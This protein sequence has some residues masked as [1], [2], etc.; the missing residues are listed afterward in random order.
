[1]I[2]IRKYSWALFL[3]LPF[4]GNGQCIYNGFDDAACNQVITSTDLCNTWD[5]NCGAGWQ[6]SSGTPSMVPYTTPKGLTKYYIFMWAQILSNQTY[7]ESM[8]YTLTAGNTFL[9]NHTYNITFDVVG[10]G[11]GAVNF[12]AANTLQQSALTTCGNNL[13]QLNANQRQLIGTVAAVNGVWV[14]SVTL[15]FVANANYNQIWIYPTSVD[16]NQ[17]SMG[18]EYLT[19]CEDPCPATLIYNTGVVPEGTS[20]AGNIIA[21]TGVPGTATVSIQPTQTTL[22]TADEVDLI[23]NFDATV[24]TGSFTATTGGC[25]G[26]RPMKNPNRED[27]DP[28]FQSGQDFMVMKTNS[29]PITQKKVTPGENL[30][31][32]VY[33]TIGTGIVNITGITGSSS[34]VSVFDQ[35]GKRVLVN[36]NTSKNDVNRLDLSNLS[37]GIYYI[38]IKNS[39][40]TINKKVIIYK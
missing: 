38:Q 14:N 12:Y 32:R 16:A 30:G 17:Y 9:A 4:Y 39:F 26:F 15:T 36:R 13:P 5:A 18:I 10:T 29:S 27:Y 28:P 33:P 6:R 19:A 8:F 1:M 3:F 40:G 31:I 21:G 24:T 7:G 2:L 22:L 25:A 37:N 20:R 11:N 23:A 35:L 34:V